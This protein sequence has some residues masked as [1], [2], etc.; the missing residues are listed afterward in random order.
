MSLSDIAED[1]LACASKIDRHANLAGR[2]PTS[3]LE[4]TL[5]QLPEDVE[6]ARK[7]LVDKTQELRQLALGPVGLCLDV[8]FSVRQ[9]HTNKGMRN[10]ALI[11]CLF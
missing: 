3:F 9:R 8:L 6:Q 2:S 1:I 5:G 11:S 10:L 7:T 4:D